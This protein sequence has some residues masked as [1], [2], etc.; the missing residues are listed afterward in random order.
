M[1]ESEGQLEEN[2]DDLDETE[3]QE[4]TEELDYKALY[5][6]EK[7]RADKAENDWKSQRGLL[8]TQQERDEILHNLNDEV[9]ALRGTLK[10]MLEGM[11]KGDTEGLRE[12]VEETEQKV[13]QSRASRTFETQYLRAYELLDEATKDDEGNLITDTGSPEYHEFVSDWNE[14]YK[15]GD[16]ATLFELT[17]EA[18]KERRQWDRQKASSNE[19]AGKRK[20]RQKKASMDLGPAGGGAGSSEKS[21]LQKIEDGLKKRGDIIIAR[22]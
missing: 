2:L 14:A 6:G 12:Q 22:H 15:K 18:Q 10:G 1:A 5:E 17:T 11:I 13:A 4:E 16:I 3:E 21:A 20:E 8:K 9:T 19:N 7:T